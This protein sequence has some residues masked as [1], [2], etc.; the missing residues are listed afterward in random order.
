MTTIACG[1]IQSALN[2]PSRVER[3][4]FAWVLRD[5]QGLQPVDA[6]DTAKPGD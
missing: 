4:A 6:L 3:L 2:D 1:W 5:G